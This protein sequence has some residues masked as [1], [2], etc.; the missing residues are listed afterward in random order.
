[1]SAERI[2]V[3]SA[4]NLKVFLCGPQRDVGDRE[5]RSALTNLGR[6]KPRGS[7]F[8]L[9]GKRADGWGDGCAWGAAEAAPDA[10]VCSDL[11]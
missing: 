3:Q 6:R 2:L 4:A 5:W 11:A 1:M 8:R 7:W 9:R 10:W